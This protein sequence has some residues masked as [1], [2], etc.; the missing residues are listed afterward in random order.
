VPYFRAQQGEAIAQI[1]AK[2]FYQDTKGWFWIG[3]QRGIYRFDGLDCDPFMLPDSVAGAPQASVQF[4]QGDTLWVGFGTGHI[5]YLAHEQLFPAQ[6]ARFGG[7]RASNGGKLALWEP[8]EGTPKKAI[9]GFAT[10][11]NGYLWISTYGEGL[12]VWNGRHLFQFNHA[13]DNL[14]SDEIYAICSDND[15]QIWAATDNGISVVAFSPKEQKNV[16]NLSRADGLPDEIV[17]ALQKDNQG[18]IWIGTHD[19]G[20]CFYEA[21][22]RQLRPF[23][24]ASWPYGEVMGIAV[25]EGHEAWVSTT[26]GLVQCSVWGTCQLLSAPAKVSRLLRD[27]EGLLW[28][29]GEQG[30]LYSANLAVTVQPT[31]LKG[32]LQAVCSGPDGRVWAGTQEG[33]FV[34]NGTA[35]SPVGRPGNVISLLTLPNGQVWAG[36]FG[37]G[38]CIYDGNTGRSVRCIDLA[39]G[40]P[41]GS[42][43]SMAAA[44]GRIWV[45]TLGG[46]VGID[47]KTNHV[48]PLGRVTGNPETDRY[49]VYKL[50]ADSKDRL[51][52][53]TDGHGL[54]CWDGTRFQNWQEANGQS[55]K[56]IYTIAEDKRGH[57]WF[58][59][60]QTHLWRYDGAAFKQLTTREHLH[61]PQ[62]TSLCTTG[63][64]QLV[65]GYPDGVDLVTPDSEHI[66]FLSGNTGTPPIDAHLNAACTDRSGHVWLGLT[67]GLGRV[68]SF[69]QGYAFD[70][71][72]QIKTVANLGKPIDPHTTNI[73]AHDENHLIFEYVG[74]WLTNPNSV[75]YR[76]RLDGF[77]PDWTISKDRI[78]SY[79]NLPPGTYCFRVQSS[80]HG[81]FENTR[82]ANYAFTIRK[83]FWAE[84]WFLCACIA[85]LGTLVAWY[86]KRRE[87]RLRREEEM[88]NE[89]IA[90]Q[91]DVLKTQISPHFL[92]NS[93]NT[94]IT[95]IEEN[96]KVAVDYVEHLADFYRS[97]MVYREK[98]FIPLAEELDIV[99]NFGYLLK[100]R[101]EDALQ[102]RVDVP[103][104]TGKVMPLTLQLLLENAVKHNVISKAQPLQIDIFVENDDTIVVR[105][106][107]NLKI[108]PE[109]GTRFGL[110]SLTQRYEVLTGRQ[111]VVAQRDGVFEVRV[112]LV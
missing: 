7:A 32:G 82:E 24:D 81:R 69:A 23:S 95:I 60:E 42:I 20:L 84:W 19:N 40:L 110:Q 112:P 104:P 64:G 58:S 25:Y 13:D 100:R 52:C 87:Q 79:P 5:G 21:A 86:I 51:W 31:A 109:P 88:K 35:W 17:T 16:R 39:Q 12:Y 107:K 41:N 28:L 15:G 57:I 98:D 50:F 111:L 30:N 74:V 92:F 90:A 55:F 27:R 72:S 46:V 33:L 11:R 102:I 73:F 29:L 1:K 3:S 89:K 49:Y 85:L 93:F 38:I 47:P 14:C 103:V 26:A 80:E 83:P 37:N 62:I 6:Y 4:Q 94:L 106:N 91:L 101:Y 67:N 66:L 9:T 61:G 97:I 10:D 2:S 65:V 63:D 48:Q 36:T 99:H 34:R 56:T 76:Y 43:L 22:T 18:N 78:A 53:C 45:A 75:Y 71:L 96:P 8:Q 59:G 108:K 105:N 44:F 77:D 68:A 70:P 54:A